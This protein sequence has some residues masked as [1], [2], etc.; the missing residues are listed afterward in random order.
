METLAYLHHACAH[1]AA[2]T[3][4][5]SPLSVEYLPRQSRT[6][7]IRVC[8]LLVSLG[9]LSLAGAA[10]ALQLGDRGAA[11]TTLQT[12]LQETGCFTG[13]VDGIFGPQTDAGVKCFQARNG[14]TADG[15]VGSQT[16]A[17]LVGTGVAAQPTLTPVTSKVMRSGDS[18]DDVLRM[19]TRLV[20]LQYDAPMTGYF[21][22]VTMDA[23]KQ[24]QRDRGLTVDGVVGAQTARA[25]GLTPSVATSTPLSP[26]TPPAPAG[27]EVVVSQKTLRV[28]SS[29]A[30]VEALQNRLKALGFFNGP[31]TGYYGTL[32]QAAVTRYQQSRG[33]AATGV[34]DAN[35]LNSIG[36]VAGKM[37]SRRY[38]VV[39][40]Q[41]GNNLLARVRRD[42][43]NA[44]IEK[45]RLGNFVNAGTF[46][47]RTSADR[48]SAFLRGRGLDARVA[49]Q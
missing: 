42:V 18:S 38:V 31:V 6:A 44:T 21:G 40:P 39:I 26:S 46:F 7:L 2:L 5:D 4:T 1:E 17:V 32:T 30:E 33:L 41:E 43:P 10:A 47:D 37:A 49:Y 12:Q 34:A 24:F 25:L 15:I 19:Q 48:Q 27:T 35:T 9:I 13:T 45:S 23:V 28:G 14:L 3:V 20:E 16:Q 29:G 36:A 11:V 22:T 8:S